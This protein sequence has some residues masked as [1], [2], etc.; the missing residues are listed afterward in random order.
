MCRV[1]KRYK[2]THCGMVRRSKWGIS[3]HACRALMVWSSPHT[4]TRLS[5]VRIE[6]ARITNLCGGVSDDDM[7]SV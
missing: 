4:P 3:R 6:N 7:Y 1:R 2:C 5:D